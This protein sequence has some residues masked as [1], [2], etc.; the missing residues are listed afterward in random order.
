[1]PITSSPDFNPLGAACRTCD[2]PA[3]TPCRGRN[4]RTHPDRERAAELAYVAQL[5]EAV[6]RRRRSRFGRARRQVPAV[7]VEVESDG[8]VIDD[9]T[10]KDVR[11]LDMLEWIDWAERAQR[12]YF[13]EKDR[14]KADRKIV[15]RTDRTN[16]VRTVLQALAGMD[17][18]TAVERIDQVYFPEAWTA[19]VRSER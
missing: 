16:R 2:A 15:K 18:D 19:P 17:I 1:M 7:V 6:A 13:Q 4:H 9:V 10:G 5:E 14:V 11:H 3:D 8:P 12:R